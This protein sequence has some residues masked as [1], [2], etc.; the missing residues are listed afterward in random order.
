MSQTILRQRSLTN[1][2]QS[3]TKS[4]PSTPTLRQKQQ[5]SSLIEKVNNVLTVQRTSK[6]SA[7]WC[8]VNF[9]LAVICYCKVL[10]SIVSSLLLF[11]H[12]V[13]EYIE[14][15]LLVI[16]TWNMLT[17]LY[18]FCLPVFQKNHLVLNDKQKQLLGIDHTNEKYFTPKGFSPS[19]NSNKQTT[20]SYNTPVQGTPVSYPTRRTPSRAAS[21]PSMGS[22]EYSPGQTQYSSGRHSSGRTPKYSPQRNSSSY[23]Q[24]WN[25]PISGSQ[26]SQYSP[27]GEGSPMMNNS[28]NLSFSN[29]PSASVFLNNS[30]GQ[31]PRLSQTS[32]GRANS[33]SSDQIYDYDTLDKFIQKEEENDLKQWRSHQDSPQT[34]S[35]WSFGRT[36]YDF[37]PSISTYQLATRSQTTNRKD[38]DDDIGTENYFKNDEMW[39]AL[40]INQADAH[41]WTEHLRKWLAETVLEPIVFEINNVND[42]LTQLGNPELHIGSVSHAALQKLASTKSQ[43]LPSLTS[44]LP[45]LNVTTNQ[46]YLVA[47]LKELSNGGC[48]RLYK[49]NEG[50]QYNNKPWNND[51]P[52]DAQIMCH[53]LCTYMDTHLPSNPRHNEGKSFTGLH[54]LKTPQKPV[55]KKSALCIYQTRVQNPHFKVLLEDSVCDIPRGRNNFFHSVVVFLYYAKKNYYG[56]LERVNL[57]MSGINVLWILDKK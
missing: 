17:H 25:T 29:T 19:Y 50:G 31:S 26:S 28:A 45:Y 46:E 37:M 39:K 2:K 18:Y 55:N 35:I 13:V 7:L 52:T 57:G 47:R 12:I 3:P 8:L 27:F 21:T 43:H 49:W 24:S 1:L 15:L 11:N 36:A 23:R 51:L 16:F 33:P 4:Y 6:K 32:P 30:I 40:G 5:A 48:L 34:S 56:M 41:V 9:V 54:F 42:R 14:S 53:L 22:L 10:E 44:L 20:P 38:D